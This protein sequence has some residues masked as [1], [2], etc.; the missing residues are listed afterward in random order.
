MYV[1]R[2]GLW[3]RDYNNRADS[4]REGQWSECKAGL[5]VYSG[6]W[7]YWTVGYRMELD[8]L[9]QP[10]RGQSGTCRSPSKTL[11]IHLKLFSKI[12]YESILAVVCSLIDFFNF[13]FSGLILSMIKKKKKKIKLGS[14][15]LV[16]S[17]YS[18]FPY[19]LLNVFKI[20]SHAPQQYTRNRN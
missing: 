7:R 14:C 4:H 8:A 1:S 6:P 19:V 3:S 10:A 20:L 17:K 9:W 18:I 2:F 5:P 15:L 16:G 12:A 13:L 11:K